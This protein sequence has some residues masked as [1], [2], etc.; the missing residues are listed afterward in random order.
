MREPDTLV[1]LVQGP[2]RRKRPKM[3]LQPLRGLLIGYSSALGL[4][5]CFCSL[6]R[7]CPEAFA[8]CACRRTAVVAGL[9]DIAQFYRL[10]R[11]LWQSRPPLLEDNA[12][13]CGRFASKSG[14]LAI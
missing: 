10:L 3:R 7:L 1:A 12:R 13:R 6:G 14:H 5:L 2:E 8:G 9:L 4:R 11:I